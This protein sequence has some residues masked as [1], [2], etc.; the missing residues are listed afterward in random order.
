M[1]PKTL[2]D[3]I[4][5]HLCDTK[6]VEGEKHFILE[7]PEYIYIKFHFENICNNNDLHKLSTHQNCGDLGKF[8]SNIF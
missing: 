5:C 1:I 6:K 2:W 3:E 7:F 8:P 4:I